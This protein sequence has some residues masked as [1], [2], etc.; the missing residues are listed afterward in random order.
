MPDWLPVVRRPTTLSS[1]ATAPRASV[2][3]DK[4]IVDAAE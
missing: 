3:T 4:E 1:L 2:I